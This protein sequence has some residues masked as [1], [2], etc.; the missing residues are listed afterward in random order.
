[1]VLRGVRIFA[2]F[3]AAVCC[4]VACA[5]VPEVASQQEASI[6]RGC[7][8]LQDLQGDRHAS[9]RKVL[10]TC[11]CAAAAFAQDTDAASAHEFSIAMEAYAQAREALVNDP[12]AMRA[13][14][15]RAFNRQPDAFPR[16][17]ADEADLQRL[18][19]QVEAC[20]PA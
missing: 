13:V 6:A 14:L 3:G 17:Q 4:V 15:E 20:A 5:T 16:P 19:E 7:V 18:A 8:Y 9:T 1:M 12:A 2:L 11:A 10:R